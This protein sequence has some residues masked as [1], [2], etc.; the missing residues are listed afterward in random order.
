MSV[1][2]VAKR[3]PWGIKVPDDS[4]QTIYVWLDALVNYYTVLGYPHNSPHSE[5]AEIFRNII[6]I[7]GKDILKFH[8]II[9]PSLLM[10]N[11]Y[12]MPASIVVH[13]FWILENVKYSNKNTIKLDENVE[14]QRECDFCSR[15][16]RKK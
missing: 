13:N 9:W 4:E 11:K 6:H 16:L 14:E 8:T 7:I 2:R 1:S 10:A 3:I 12:P 5:N 15:P